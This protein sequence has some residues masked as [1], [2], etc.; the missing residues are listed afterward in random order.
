M[1]IKVIACE[2]LFR[3][4]HLAAAVSPQL[5]DVKFLPRECHDDLHL[6]RRMLDEELA[7]TNGD[8]GA[9]VERGVC[10]PA[11]G[12][13][14]YNSVVLVMGLCGNTVQGLRAPDVPLVLPKVHDCSGLL[15]GGND[16][17]LAE[18]KRTVF[19]H[20]GAVEQLGAGLVD[21]VPKKYG[22]GRSLQEYIGKYG[23]DNGRYIFEMEHHFVAYNERALVLKHPESPTGQAT[24][25]KVSEYVAKA[26]FGWRVE[27][28]AVDMTLFHRLLAGDWD[29]THFLVVPPGQT[30]KVR[31]EEGGA[32]A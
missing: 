13:R 26:Q 11:C 1:R 16:R 14:R 3:E 19:Y 29:P 30:V 24:H 23:E 20:Q 22:L 10:C 28:R 6:M 2:T 31:V 15:L 4:I 9:C 17:Y 12:T 21:A 18:E 8:G 7:A 27:S 5:C 25:E 32:I